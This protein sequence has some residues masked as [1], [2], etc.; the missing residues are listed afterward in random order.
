MSWRQKPIT[1][2][3]RNVFMTFFTLCSTQSFAAQVENGNPLRFWQGHNKSYLQGTFSA[4]LAYFDQ[5]KSWFGNARENIGDDSDSWW[6]GV[7]RPGIEGKYIL[8]NASKFY[9][10]VDAVQANTQDI[11]GAGTNV[12][13]GDVSKIR[14]EEFYAG[15]SSG[16]NFSSLGKDFLDISFG[17]QQYIVGNG[18][19]FYSQSSNGGDRGAYWLADRHTADYSAIIR[20]KSGEWKGDLVYFKADDNPNM[21]TKVGGITL[22]YDAG[23]NGGVG[24]GAY[25]INSDDNFRDEMQVYDIRFNFK[26]FSAFDVQA[27]KPF[28]LEG[29][30]VYE[31]I[32]D[33]D[34]D[35]GNGW[36][37]QLSYQFEDLTWKPSLTYRYSGFDKDYDPLF[38]GFSDWGYWYQGE[39]LGEY[40]LTN[41]NLNSQMVKLNVQPVE[42]L[43]VNLFYYNLRLDDAAA[44]GVDDKNYGDEIDLIIDWTYNNHLSFSLV[45]AYASPDDAAKQQTN[46]DDDWSYMMLYTKISF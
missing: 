6:E 37:L 40:V 36:Y 46:G 41:S 30:Y 13:Y 45:G 27:L 9:G 42:S 39:I 19:L 23:K 29:E 26:I 32:D 38:Y 4:E 11:D 16:E 2:I 22:D 12:E 28:E 34:S 35:N 14:I 15:W 43:S 21:N 3:L 18:F 33:S 31:N 25:Y 44:F 1:L 10:R 8:A 20:M 5:S 7:I 24:G 17:R